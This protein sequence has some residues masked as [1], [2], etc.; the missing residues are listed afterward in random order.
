[1]NPDSNTGSS[2]E[3]VLVG[4]VLKPHGIRGELKVSIISDFPELLVQRD[5]LYVETTTGTQ[6]RYEVSSSRL[7]GGYFY[8]SLDEI[9]DRNNAELLRGSYI[10]VP[11]KDIAPLE[12][13]SV[14]AFDLL[15]MTVM[16]ADQAYYGMV[17]DVNHFPSVDVLVVEN[18]E[19][20]FMLPALN[21]LLV[22]IDHT[23]RTLKVLLPE[24]LPVYPIGTR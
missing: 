15:G 9:S 13:G 24:G 18:E 22:E 19:R 11:K 6:R 5:E 2:S 16:G 3:F 8:V 14:Y 17:V 7:A 20:W 21:E 4:Q 10:S 12:S 1:M 23:R